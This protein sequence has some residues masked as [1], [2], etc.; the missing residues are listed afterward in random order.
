MGWSVPMRG[1]YDE[2]SNSFHEFLDAGETCRF[3][4]DSDTLITFNG[5]RFDMII[6]ERDA[7][8]IAFDPLREIP[9]LDVFTMVWPRS[10]LEYVATLYAPEIGPRLQA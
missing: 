7:G 2:A 1:G 4:A 10:T 3:L 8:P 6:L 9:H 5:P